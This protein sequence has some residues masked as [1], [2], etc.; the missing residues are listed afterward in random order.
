MKQAV[1]SYT[2]LLLS[3]RDLS[4]ASLRLEDIVG[5]YLMKI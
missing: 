5:F 3:K 2:A 1:P 4:A